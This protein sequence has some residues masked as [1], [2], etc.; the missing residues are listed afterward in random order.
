MSTARELV[1]KTRLQYLSGTKRSNECENSIASSL[2][3]LDRPLPD[4]ESYCMS[5]SVAYSYKTHL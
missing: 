3:L 4:S 1:Q 5:E 2:D